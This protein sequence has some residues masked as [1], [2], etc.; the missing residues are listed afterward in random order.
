VS[1]LRRLLAALGAFARAS[2]APRLAR[3]VACDE[4]L[5]PWRAGHRVAERRGALR[6][7][8]MPRIATRL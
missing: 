7:E 4:V 2:L 1:E 6:A 8:E 5:V 3:Q